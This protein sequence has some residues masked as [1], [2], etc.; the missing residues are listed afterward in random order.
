M[1]GE[2]HHF[3]QEQHAVV[4][5]RDL[6]RLRYRP[7]ADKTGA[8]DGVVR[9]AE[10]AGGDKVP[11]LTQHSRDGIYRRDFDGLFL[12]ERRQDCRHARRQHRLARARRAHHQ[13]VVPA[14]RGDFQRALGVLLALDVGEVELE[15]RM[16]KQLVEGH[17]RLRLDLHIATQEARRFREMVHRIDG[18]PFEARRFGR[19]ARR[20]QHL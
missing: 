6:A 9:M 16:L 12:R 11:L 14:R 18:Q 1:L 3:I 2:L 8:G 17:H 20:H 19:V 5:Q 10:G 13:H 4:R 15:R 7:A